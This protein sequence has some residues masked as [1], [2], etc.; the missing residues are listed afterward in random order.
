M[1][2]IPP[3]P[4]S[5]EREFDEDFSSAVGIAILKYSRLDKGKR[6]PG[7]ELLPSRREFRSSGS[8]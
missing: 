6:A 1:L 3:C 8:C 7:E 5:F 4:I 2:P